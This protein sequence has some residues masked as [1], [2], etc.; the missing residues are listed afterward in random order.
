MAIAPPTNEL[1]TNAPPT[2][3]L[4]PNAQPVNELVTDEVTDEDAL[5]ALQSF[6]S[7]RETAAPPQPKRALPKAK[8]AK[9]TTMPTT[10]PTH[11][12]PFAADD[13]DEPAARRGGRRGAC[14]GAQE[15]RDA[16]VAQVSRVRPALCRRPC[17]ATSIP[18]PPLLAAA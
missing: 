10:M 2:N 9:T 7:D 3:E 12:R 17:L 13:E 15:Q 18:D 6:A 4:V 11:R 14:R 1:V 8:R 16:D 5:S